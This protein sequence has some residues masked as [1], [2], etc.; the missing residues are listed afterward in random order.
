MTEYGAKKMTYTLIAVVD[1]NCARL[2]RFEESDF[3]EQSPPVFTE[4][5]QILNSVRDR[6]A[7]ALWSNTQSGHNRS[8]GSHTYGYDD[9]R[10]NH[11]REFERRFVSDLVNE[12]ESLKK[13][14][15]FN[16]LILVA[17]PQMLGITRQTLSPQ[18]IESVDFQEM[19]KDLSK[20]TPTEIHKYLAS[21]DQLPQPYRVS[22]VT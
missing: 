14:A 17:A 8:V 19:A 4:L 21:K 15:P 11:I 2:F 20:F 6:S 22:R 3:P 12:I 16:R 9:H 7:Q 18:I 1:H 10:D 5:N 13:A